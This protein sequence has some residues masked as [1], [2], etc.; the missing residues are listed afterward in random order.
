MDADAKTGYKAYA[1]LA[2]IKKHSDD[3]LFC[4]TQTMS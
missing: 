1:R 3:Y 4:L 2:Q